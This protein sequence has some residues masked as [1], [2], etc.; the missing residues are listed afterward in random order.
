[1]INIYDYNSHYFW[2][3]GGGLNNVYDLIRSNKQ[4]VVSLV[5]LLFS[6]AAVN[7]SPEI[8]SRLSDRSSLHHHCAESSLI[9]RNP[10]G[11]VAWPVVQRLP[12]MFWTVWS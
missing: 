9:R 11:K 2:K 5:L 8:R 10:A 1:M 4:F 7:N 3:G 12:W 6:C